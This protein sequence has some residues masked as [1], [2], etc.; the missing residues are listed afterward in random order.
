MTRTA[1]LTAIVI[2]GLAIAIAAQAPSFPPVGNAEKIKDN[3]YVIQG[4]GGNTAVLVTAN[5]VTLVDTKLANNGQAILGKVKAVTSKPVTTIINTHTHGDHVGSNEAF[6]ASVEIIA[7]ENTRANMAKMD[8]LKG[9][10][11]AMPDRVFKDTLTIGSGADQVDLY[12]FGAGHTNGDTFVV[13]RNART[14]HAGDMFAW[15][16]PPFVDT[17]S[18]GSFV[19]LPDSLEKASK[20]IQNV[21]TIITGHMGSVQPWAKLAEYAEFNREFLNYVQAAR[22]AGKTADQAA[23][24]LKLPAKFKAYVGPAVVPGA[25]FIGPARPFAQKNVAAAYAEM[26]ARR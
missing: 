13:F 18:G 5:G 23:A 12:Y 7:H 19:A 9:K 17:M 15:S 21:D 10:P 24:E 8:E 25:E 1:I 3:L 4:Q 20:G 22:K 11:N 14:V 6:P 16:A 2:T 26:N